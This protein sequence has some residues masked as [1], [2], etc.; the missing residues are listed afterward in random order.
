[1]KLDSITPRILFALIGSTILCLGS[2]F[3]YSYLTLEKE[4]FSKLEAER[5]VAGKQARKNLAIPLY[6]FDNQ[7]AMQVIEGLM[8]NPNIEAITIRDRFLPQSISLSYKRDDQ[9]HLT[10]STN[11]APQSPLL[12]THAIEHQGQEI[13]SIEIL[14]TDRYIRKALRQTLL[15]KLTALFFLTSILSFALFFMLRLTVIEPLRRLEKFALSIDK[16]GIVEASFD[17]KAFAKEVRHV[18]QAMLDMLNQLRSRIQELSESQQ[19]LKKNETLLQQSQK[20]EAI[21][22]LAGG[23]AHDFNNV[24]SGIIGYTEIM[25]LN[26]PDGTVRKKQLQQVLSGGRRAKDLVKQ[27]LAFSRNT[28]SEKKPF[29]LHELVEEVLALL[30]VS[31]PV[32]IEL[33]HDILRDCGKVLADPSQFHQILMN[34]FTNASHAMEK[35]GGTLKV[36]AH[37]I[38]TLPDKLKNS[39]LNTQ[40]SF[41]EI[42]ISDTGTGI[43]EDVLDRI[44]D[45]F[46]TTKEK[47]KGTGMG[48]SVVYG[49][50]KNMEGTILVD[51]T[52]GVGTTFSIYLPTIESTNKPAQTV[53]RRIAPNGVGTIMVVDDEEMIVDVLRILLEQMGYRT[54]I[55]TRSF[56]ALQAFEAH[57]DSYDLIITDYAMPGINGIELVDRCIEIRSSIPILLCT[58]FSD[59]IDD[60]LAKSR[61]VKA[62]VYKPIDRAQL[63][64]LLDTLLV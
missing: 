30:R 61:G 27:I 16:D 39:G 58:G 28:Q 7:Q 33:Q 59:K 9:G 64:R 21:G 22:Q 14:F 46:F 34:V 11:P 57:P 8:I 62:F 17:D 40:S 44:F 4:Y 6:N 53:P 52:V 45:P 3:A 38:D 35:T 10:V 43:E 49:I 63:T 1:M 54:A 60:K 37:P 25:L 26:E 56:D 18:H 36:T 50:V 48:L 55:F 13:G 12:D 47:G 20:M 19:A 41:V 29:E 15:S 5:L 32:V 51:S 23:I 42:C 24:L 31:I 2:Y